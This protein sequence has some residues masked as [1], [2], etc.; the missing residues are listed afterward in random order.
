MSDEVVYEQFEQTGGG[1]AVRR[2]EADL[3]RLSD[4]P[5]EA[6]VEIG[7]T[8]MTVGDTLNLRKRRGGRCRRAVR[9]ACQ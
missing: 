8:A 2:S 4:V 7:R 3:R 1:E 5:M 6:S 9:P